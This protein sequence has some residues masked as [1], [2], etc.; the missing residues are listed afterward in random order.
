MEKAKSLYRETWLLRL[1]RLVELFSSI[2][3]ES[4]HPL[5]M[6]RKVASPAHISKLLKL[7]IYASPNVKLIVLKIIENL[8]RINLPNELFNE[9][10]MMT[11]NNK[12]AI[13]SKIM[14]S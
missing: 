8:V 7:L 6:I 11:C 2:S 1:L 9:A 3:R 14:A 10:V 5:V 4:Q 12:A 13:P